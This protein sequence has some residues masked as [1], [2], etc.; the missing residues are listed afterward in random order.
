MLVFSLS[1]SETLRE[2]KFKWA[3][4]GHGRAFNLN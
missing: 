1:G 3:S 2:I 4:L